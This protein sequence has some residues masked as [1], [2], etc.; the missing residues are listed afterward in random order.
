MGKKQ[1]WRVL[2]WIHNEKDQTKQFAAWQRIGRPSSP[3]VGC[4]EKGAETTKHLLRLPNIIAG[5]QLDFPSGVISP[6]TRYLSIACLPYVFLLY[7]PLSFYLFFIFLSVSLLSLFLLVVII[8]SLVLSSFPSFTSLS[9]SLFVF[10]LSVCLS[11][12]LSICESIHHF[13]WTW[14]RRIQ[15]LHL[16]RRCRA[17]RKNSCREK[18]ARARASVPM[19]AAP[20]LFRE[21]PGRDQ[22]NF[23]V[24]LV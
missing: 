23:R 17:R 16:V 13:L 15:S 11:T 9:P 24:A 8:L 18:R 14:P 20:S 4:T 2:G 3:F 5:N 10:F 12:S 1:L 21:S 7:F 6:E 19:G 22:A